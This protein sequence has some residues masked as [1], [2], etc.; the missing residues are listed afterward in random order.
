M[1]S[2]QTLFAS[3]AA[4]SRAAVVARVPER[5]LGALLVTDGLL[6][7]LVLLVLVLLVLLLP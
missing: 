5:A 3:P 6:A 2:L 7:G 1:S 4:P